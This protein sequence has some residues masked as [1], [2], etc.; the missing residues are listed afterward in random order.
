MAEKSVLFLPVRVSS[1]DFI[2]KK[3]PLRS[4]RVLHTFL[5]NVTGKL[6]LGQWEDFPAYTVH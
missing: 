5:H 3:S 4:A 1:T 6:V 2:D